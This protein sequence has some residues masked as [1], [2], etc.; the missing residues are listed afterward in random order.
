[1]KAAIYSRKSKFTGKG[2]SIENQ[3]Q[4]CKEYAEK[5]G[6]TEHIVYEDEGF[7]GGNVDRPQF[8]KMLRD[9][10]CK[11]FDILICY[12]LDRISR[13]IAD[14][15]TLINELQTLNIGFISIKEQF[16]TSTPMGRAMM[17]IASVFAQLERETI[18]ERVKDNM[19][20]LARTG[21]WL[22]GKTPLGFNS[23]AVKYFDSKMK[24]RKMYKLTPVPEEL[25]IVKL[26]FAKYIE[27]GGI[28]KL[29]GYCIK[30]NIRS[31][32]DSNFDKTALVFILT[33]P[34]YVIADQ[35][36]YEYCS[37]KNMDIASS[38]EDF[39][40]N[41]GVMVY[42]K[43]VVKP[44]K[45]VKKRDMSEWIVAIGKHKGIISSNDWIKVQNLLH[46]NS[47]KAPREGTSRIA[48]LT[49]LLVC[50]NCGNKLRVSY[51]YENGEIKHHYYKCKLKERSRKTQCDM[52]NLNGIE[53]EMLVMEELKRLAVNKG[54]LAKKLGKVKKK[55]D[56]DSKN[57]D[58]E[59]IK[60]G[61]NIKDLESSIENLTLQLAQNTSSTAAAHIIKQIEKLDKEL[62]NL[63]F[64]LN[65]V[66]RKK[67]NSLVKQINFDMLQEHLSKLSANIDTMDFENKKKILKSIIKEIVWD[68]EKLKIRLLGTD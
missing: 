35:L 14:F 60:L 52:T 31:K 10:K 55:L 62:N 19:H 67:D 47:L 20:Q 37:S 8:K 38:Y 15:S 18:A 53:A 63:K 61:K 59:Q 30:N 66:E 41:N 5:M 48:L 22:G 44:N 51:K 1:M 26:L 25:Q 68:G 32:K 54:A 49:P 6:I 12:R 56:A 17:Y 16:D 11:N 45:S 4:L 2:E 23:Q 65:D 58:N 24:A 33:N 29:E 42:N 40:G 13:N 64:E 39:N 36:F 9:A 34:V 43:R 50:A 7:S 21:R 3:V 28:N 46:E 57:A 27:L